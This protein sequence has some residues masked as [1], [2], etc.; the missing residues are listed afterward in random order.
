MLALAGIGID[1]DVGWGGGL[2]A[3]K[4]LRGHNKNSVF[5]TDSSIQ[6]AQFISL[7]K[8]FNQQWFNSTKIE[9]PA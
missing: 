3:I 9:A 2:S 7:A 4:L 6:M 5:S 8:Q 1:G